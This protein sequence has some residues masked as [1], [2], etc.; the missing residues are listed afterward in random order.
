MIGGKVHTATVVSLETTDEGRI[1]TMLVD[2][3]DRGQ[4]RAYLGPGLYKFVEA[5]EVPVGTEV[6]ITYR[7]APIVLGLLNDRD[8]DS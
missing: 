6:L 1:T 3:L 7:A 8:N 4:I 2:T 5:S